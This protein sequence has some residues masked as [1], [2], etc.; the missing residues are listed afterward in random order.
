MSNLL[1]DFSN[2]SKQTRIQLVSATPPHSAKT[3][4]GVLKPK[5]FIGVVLILF[6]ILSIFCVVK[7][8]LCKGCIDIVLLLVKYQ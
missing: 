7:R 5:H 2:I 3:S 8:Q 4:A 1:L 6:T